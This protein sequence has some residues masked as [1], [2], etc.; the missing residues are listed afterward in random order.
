[1]SRFQSAVNC[2]AVDHDRKS[3]LQIPKSH[4]SPHSYVYSININSLY[5]MFSA[6]PS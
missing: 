1:M 4:S 5:N 6:F 3:K 2:F